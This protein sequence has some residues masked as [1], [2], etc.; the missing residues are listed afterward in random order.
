MLMSSAVPQDGNYEKYYA[1]AFFDAEVFR[2][3]KTLFDEYRSTGVILNDS[4][5]DG[6]WRFTN[7]LNNT[8]ISFHFNELNFQKNASPWIG[9]NYDLFIDSVKAYAMLQLG[10]TAVNNIREV[11]NGFRLFAELSEG[12]LL[13]A[14]LEHSAHMAEFLTALPGENPPRDAMI[15]AFE[16][17]QWNYRE[18]TGKNRQRVLSEL[19]TYFKFNDA[20]QELWKSATGDE[21]LFWFPLYLWWTL[22]AILPLRTTEFLLTPRKCLDIENGKSL[23]TLRRTLLKGGG[24]RIAYRIEKDYETVRYVIPDK[25]ADEIMWYLDATRAMEASSLSTLFFREPHYA[26]FGKKPYGNLG[27]YTYVNL[28]TCLRCFQEEI[29]GVNDE[30]KIHL[31]D[32]R[33]LAMIGLILSGGSPLICKE[34]AGHED[35]NISAHYYSNI[36]SFIECATFE[37][38][39]K[40][41]AS[42][43]ELIERRMPFVKKQRQSI[44]V[45]DGFCDSEVYGCGDIYDCLKS[46]GANGELGNCRRCPHFICGES[47]VHFLYENPAER[48]EHVDRDSQYLLQTLE[49]VRRGIGLPEDIQSA[50]LRLQYSGSRYSQCI[51]E[52][53]CMEGS[54]WQDQEK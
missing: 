12:A 16:E 46:I 25:M 9:C 52:N 23:I 8:T 20:I 22:T 17:K 33:H 30:S 4:F 38:H 53:Y 37:A 36:S 24:R 42:V 39:R 49:A 48:K 13:N 15:E 1:A 2:K 28:S 6:K 10:S 21:K 7:Q 31:G 3:A 32:T 26:R 11:V 5:S 14:A 29:L 34:L 50:L 35:I 51:C 54:L 43:A 18:R 40:S 45:P 41:R 27:Y 44:P 47:G 19:G